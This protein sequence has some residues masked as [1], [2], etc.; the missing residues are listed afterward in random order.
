M[1]AF[2]YAIML[3][4]ME[5]R[6]NIPTTLTIFGA[7][8]DL[9]QR[10]IIPSLF[11]LYNKGNLPDYF[12]IVAFARKD[13]GNQGYREFA[14]EALI[15]H[16]QKIKDSNNLHDFLE[17]FEYHRGDLN[18]DASYLELKKLLSSFDQKVGICTNK[19]F[20]L[21]VPPE[22]YVNIFTHLK[23]SGLADGCG[24]LEGWTR[25]IVE[26]PFGEDMKTAEK[27]DT[28]LGELFKEEQIYRIDHYLAKEMLQN[29]LS[30]RFSNNIFEEN[31]NNRFIEKIE[32][33]LWETLGVEKRGA[34]YDKIGAF[35][36][37]G[38]NHLI[39]ILAL[40]TMEHPKS[41]EASSII[42]KREEILETLV[43]PEKDFIVSNTYRSQYIG[44]R[45]IEGVREDSKTET[46]FKVKAELRHDKWV[47]VPITMEFGK[48]MK[49]QIKEIVV[50]FK[51]PS[52]CLCGNNSGHHKN[53]VIIKLEPKEEI[54]IELWSKKP[55][56]TY[57]TEKREVI[58]PYRELTERSQ[59]TEEYEKLLLDCIAGNQTLFVSSKEVAAMWRFVDPIV[60]AWKND[61]V[62]LDSYKPDTFE[63]SDKSAHIE[64]NIIEVEKTNT[65][66]IVGLGKMGAG[67]VRQ[68]LEKGYRIYGH[69]RSQEIVEELS[70]EGMLKTIG[71]KDMVEK[72]KAEKK[73]PTIIWLMLTAGE[74]ID[75]VLFE[76]GLSD[77]LE[78]GDIVIDGGNSNFNDSKRRFQKLKEGGIYFV[79]AGVSGGPSGARNG[80]SIMIGGEREVFE[81]V[82]KVFRDISIP[83]GY[84]FFDG[85]GAGHFVKMVHN[86][87]EYGMMQAIAEGFNIMKN[88]EYKLDLTEVADIYNHGSVI[89]SRLVGWLKK[90]LVLYGNDLEQI[91]STVAHTGEGKWTIEAA[92]EMG[93]EA[94][95]IE[96]S[97]EFRIHSGDMPSFT[98]KVLSA[99]R[100]QFGGHSIT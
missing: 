22:L 52:P 44:F 58:L 31:W 51:H 89:E 62:T 12:K 48:R 21:S 75:K 91:S 72:I 38:Q 90:A 8:G 100:N 83:N 18:E 82:E 24:P 99:L 47:G 35:R 68:L 10:K 7:T 65:I 88:S 42:K 43:T 33:K 16:S 40:L 74:T 30:F 70:R 85:A 79:D 78:K 49:E 6:S 17:L 25:I 3:H 50:T 1:G 94:K 57:E 64:K 15:R 39:Q 4:N 76:E 53:K 66:G 93:L 13:L 20:Y 59:Y 41:F 71:V 95:I 14:R 55:G 86:G 67:L 36:D 97:L 80:A 27:L 2:G 5:A 46:Y 87:I 84:K 63:A 32:I 92:K 26:K 61:L 37:V 77:S 9:T 29:I 19:L 54:V 56:L 23:K 34:F 98:G 60:S 81:K 73:S 11:H 69:N 28:Q 45:Q 96:G